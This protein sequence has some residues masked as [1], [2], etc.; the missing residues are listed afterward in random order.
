MEHF[1]EAFRNFAN[2]S[3]RATRNQYWTFFLVYFIICVIL[4]V[5]DV[6]A[7]TMALGAIFS[8]VVL[9]PSISIAARRLHDTGKSGWW[10]L[11]MLVPLIGWIILIVMLAQ[12]SQGENAYGPE[13]ATA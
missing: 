11:I 9:I 13:P 5:I 3:G 1:I 8:L 12:P 6:V 7:G 2:F 4:S 10:Q